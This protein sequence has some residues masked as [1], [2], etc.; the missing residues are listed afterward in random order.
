M[1]DTNKGTPLFCQIC[2]TVMTGIRDAEYHRLHG[3][4]E[5]CGINWAER[6]RKE[7]IAGWR[8]SS[9]EVSDSIK[10][11]RR[12]IFIEIDRLRGS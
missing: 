11:R 7:W 1:L 4:C 12:R 5:E 9:E 3:C 10:D 2:E 6:R 8:P